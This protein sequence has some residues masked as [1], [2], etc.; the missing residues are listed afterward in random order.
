L[1]VSASLEELI[2]AGRQTSR[3]ADLVEFLLKANDCL[4]KRFEPAYP[5]MTLVPRHPSVADPV[6]RRCPEYAARAFQSKLVRD[7]NDV[8]M[9]FDEV[10]LGQRPQGNGA[11]QP[12]SPMQLS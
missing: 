9:Y 3:V 2:P 7:D 10:T 1:Q 11:L 5:P 4:V 8:L 6:L 12:Y